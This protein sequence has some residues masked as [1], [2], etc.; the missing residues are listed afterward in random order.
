MTVSVN[1][2]RP[3]AFLAATVAAAAMVASCGGGDSSP[4]P[5]PIAATPAPAPVPAPVPI[6]P[7]SP[8]PTPVPA[9]APTP[10]ATGPTTIT[11]AVIKG[12][13]AGAFVAV[14][15]A[16]TGERLASTTTKS[17]GTYSVI[18]PFVGDVVIEA[19]SG[20]YIDEATNAPTTLSRPMRTV[21]YANGGQ[22]TAV[23][24]P[25]TSLA[26]FTAFN[27]EP[28]NNTASAF[29]SSLKAL[30][31]QFQLADVDLNTT[32]PVVTGVVNAYGRVLR[33]LSQYVYTQNATLDKFMYAG[34]T[35]GQW[36]AF[37]APY[38]TAYRAINPNSANVAFAF[39]G[40]GI[41]LS[42][43]GT[44]GGVCGVSIYSYNLSHGF[45]SSS[46]FKRYCVTGIAPNSCSSSN[47]A[48]EVA[49]R[50]PTVFQINNSRAPNLYE[51]QCAPDAIPLNLK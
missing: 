27:F 5:T 12:P 21:V 14:N 32:T 2:L 34:F 24:T 51:A 44:G 19:S 20:T 39:D 48:L 10:I 18:V 28:T 26:Y 45:F 42:G 1:R 35:P 13:L 29:N 31:A 22:V 7:I 11:G 46:L 15:N 30:A 40:A 36:A 37:S 17:D 47:R 43:T 38:T 50:E 3:L 41:S 4:A 49:I 33:G 6:S 16:T 8:V 9:P 25:L 23:V